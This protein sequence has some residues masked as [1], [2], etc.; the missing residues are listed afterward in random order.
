[1]ATASKN[2]DTLVLHG[3]AYRTDPATGA[4]AVPIYQSTSFNLGTTE[5]ADRL[6][7]FDEIG[8]VYTRLGNPTQDALEERLAA[9]EGGVAALA[10][11]SGQAATAL[12]VLT[13]VSAGDNIVTG[14]DL[15]GGRWPRRID[16]WS[17]RL[18]AAS[19]TSRFGSPTGPTGMSF[20]ASCLS[21]KALMR[22]RSG[23]LCHFRYGMKARDLQQRNPRPDDPES[24]A[25]SVRCRRAV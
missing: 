1:M 13:L 8:F 5:R 17:C 3:G 7:N 10:L 19:C 14:T 18:C 9:I 20:H 4:T 16:R 11:A 12:S 15:Y 21:P 24:P 25:R 2:I 22:L 23:P 6:V